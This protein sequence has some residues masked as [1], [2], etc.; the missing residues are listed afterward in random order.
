MKKILFALLIPPLSVFADGG[1][2]TQ[3]YIYAVG[4]ADIEKSADIVTFRFDL[5]ARGADQVK[6]NTEVQAKAAKVFA[7]LKDRRIAQNDVI[8]ESIKSEAEFEQTENSWRNR[9][10]LIGYAVTRPFKVKVRD[11]TAFPKLV[12][13]LFAIGDLDFTE[14]EGGLSKEKEMEDQM[15]D[16]AVANARSQA[17][18]TLKQ[19]GMKIDSVFAISP[20]AFPEIQTKIFGEPFVVVTGSNVPT[21]EDRA[22]PEYRLAP[23]TISQSVHVIYLISPA[24]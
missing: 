4:R 13:E 3:P 21:K 10:K 23:I 19:A 24:K 7:L 11:V 16:K 6:A 8:A 2:P 12:D 15:W 1:L 14:I 17:E 22:G 9:G 18:K 20:V 5:V